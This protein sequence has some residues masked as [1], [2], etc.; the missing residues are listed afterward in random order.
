LRAAYPEV[1]ATINS[2]SDLYNQAS[3]AY[4]LIKKLGIHNPD[5]YKAEK[6]IVQENAAKPRPTAS[7][8]PQTG[9]S[10]LSNANAF[11]N[12]LT[13]DVKKQLYREMLD[14]MKNK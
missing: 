8:S 11:A 9:D 2:S 7:L 4:T 10:P 13:D 1:A 12:G 6:A 3:S 14:S 5:A